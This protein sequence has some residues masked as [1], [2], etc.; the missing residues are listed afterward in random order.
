MSIRKMAGVAVV[1]C[2]M[3]AGLAACKHETKVYNEPTPEN[4]G[5][6][7]VTTERHTTETSTDTGSGTRMETHTDTVQK[8]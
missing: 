2:A 4:T 1:G 5:D 8:K 3:A 7:S 6:T